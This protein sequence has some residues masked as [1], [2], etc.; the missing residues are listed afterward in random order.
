MGQTHSLAQSVSD[1]TDAL[2]SAHVVD[3]AF[4]VLSAVAQDARGATVTQVCARTTL[5]KSTVSRLMLSLERLTMLER[6]PDSRMYR[7]G[8]GL[9]GLVAHVPHVEGLT[10]RAQ[11]ILQALHDEVGETVALTLPE[12]DHAY[13]ASQINSSHAIQT[14]DWTGQRIPM[15][16]QSTGRVFL[17]ARAPAALA[18]YLAK[19]RTPY[20]S[21]TRVSAAQLRAAL[22][23]VRAQGYAW[24]YEEF[25][26]GLVAVAAPVHDRDGQVI[27]AVSI[28]GPGFRFPGARQQRA[29]TR[30]VLA[31]AAALSARQ[32]GV[33]V[34]AGG[35]RRLS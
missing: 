5:P 25:E 21:K 15:Y 18:R 24:V 7:I 10:S 22:A 32:P 26:D 30:S 16:A 23:E 28:F 8:P 6:A 19:P 29:I 4:A 1:S 27:A 34:A 14:R 20:T 11:P 3:R 9:L 12:G 13:V 31:A 2:S 17:A 35:G 33:P